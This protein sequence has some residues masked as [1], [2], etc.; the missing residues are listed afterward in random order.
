MATGRREAAGARPFCG[1]MSVWQRTPTT[2]KAT[3]GAV[4][5]RLAGTRVV[6]CWPNECHGGSASPIS[7]RRR[8][9]RA[10]RAPARGRLR[11]DRSPPADRLPGPGRHSQEGRRHPP[12]EPLVGPGSA[13]PDGRLRGAR[14]GHLPP[15][16]AGLPGLHLRRDPALEVVPDHGL[17]RHHVGHRRRGPDPAGPVPEARAADCVEPRR[18]RQLRLRSHPA[19]RRSSSSSIRTGS[20]R[21]CS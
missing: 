11:D 12:G 9:T 20:A 7:R 19:N 21:R 6:P 1:V 14:L 2:P 10:Y 13:P 18:R 15:R 8:S 5:G 4:P 16:Q 3:F 17:R